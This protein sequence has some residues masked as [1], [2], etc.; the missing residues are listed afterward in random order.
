[1]KIV[2]AILLTV[3]LLV[4]NNCSDQKNASD[5]DPKD[6][7]LRQQIDTMNDAKAV[8]DSISQATKAQ[9]AQAEAI[10]GH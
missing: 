1:M 8:T 5:S 7:V 6:H 4:I 10:A 2:S 3:T 9:D